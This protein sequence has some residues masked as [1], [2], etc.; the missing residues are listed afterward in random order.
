MVGDFFIEIE[1]LQ[2]SDWQRAIDIYVEE[3]IQ[4]TGSTLGYFALLSWNEDGLTML[5][6]S[7]TAMDA[8]KA[9]TK[10]IKYQ[11]VETGLWGDCV[12]QRRPVVTN[13]YANSTTPNKKGY[14]SGHVAVIR[15]M[16]VP[17]EEGAKIR[18]ILGVGNKATN[19]SEEDT[20]RLQ[21]FANKGWS[22]MQRILAL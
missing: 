13:D 18:G 17:V 21:D 9:I 12:R 3:A 1:R 6:W 5:G 16:N 20:Q 15:H 2:T 11:L 4:I 14:P 7:K 22:K 8:C 19:Y 10:P